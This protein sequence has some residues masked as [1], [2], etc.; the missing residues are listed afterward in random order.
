M[1]GLI[2]KS[3]LI[4]FCITMLYAKWLIAQPYDPLNTALHAN[5]MKEKEKEMIREINLLRSD[6]NGYI[7]YIDEYEAESRN[8]PEKS[9]SG[10]M[11][12]TLNFTYELIDGVEKLKRIDTIWMDKPENES[13]AIESLRWDL[14]NTKPLSILQPDEG[15][16]KAVSFYAKDQDEHAWELKHIDSDGNWPWDRIRKY[17]PEMADGNENIAARYPEPTV[18]QVIIQLLIDYGVPGNGHR[19]NLLDP[20]WTHVACHEAG[21]HEG[22]YRW[23]QNFGVAR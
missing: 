8:R 23:L 2:N 13:Q 22:M 15:I 5:Y 14:I 17:S 1:T 6:P 12:Y 3:I 7:R 20:R 19:Y 9:L 10:S 21:L 18:R 11:K 16:Y 4:T